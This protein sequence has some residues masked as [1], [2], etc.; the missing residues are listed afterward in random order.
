MDNKAV[1]RAGLDYWHLLE[2]HEHEDWETF[3]ESIHPRLRANGGRLLLLTK[4]GA[5]RYSDHTYHPDDVLLFGN[6]TSG[7]PASIHE[8]F[9]R[10]DPEATLR[11][12]MVGSQRSQNLSNAAAIV[13]YE[14]LRQLDF[15]FGSQ[16]K[17]GEGEV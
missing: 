9:A 11:I 5:R 3:L 16:K 4:H 13:L 8:W 12:P 2:L 14:G 17:I 6:E 15:P 1:R 10:N 7:V